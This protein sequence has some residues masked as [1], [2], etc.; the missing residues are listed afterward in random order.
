VRWLGWLL[1]VAFSAAGLAGADSAAALQAFQRGEY[2]KAFDIWLPLATQG[3]PDA[4]FGVAYL[5]TTGQ[6]PGVPVNYATAAKFYLGAAEQWHASAQYNLGLLYYDGRG[7][8]QDLVQAFVWFQL[9]AAGG[10]PQALAD[11]DRL[12]ARLTPSQID[13]AQQLA[14]EV[15]SR[16]NSRSARADAAEIGARAEEIIRMYT[17]APAQSKT[18]ATELPVASSE[19]VAGASAQPGLRSSTS[20]T[21]AVQPSS[22][23][24]QVRVPV[25][26]QSQAAEARGPLSG[27]DL[28]VSVS[29]LESR[30]TGLL[31]PG[32]D[33]VLLVVTDMTGDLAAAKLAKQAFTE[34][35]RRLPA[36]A[37]VGLLRAQDGLKVLLDPT[38]DRA[39]LASTVESVPVSGKAG[40]LETVESAARLGDAILSKAAVRLAVLFITDS[41]IKNYREDFINPVINTSDSRDISRRFR[42]ALVRERISKLEAS[43]TA[44][45]TPVFILHL[46]YRSDSLNEAYQ[47]GLLSLSG[48]TGA[49]AWFCR[50]QAEIAE[51]VRRAFEVIKSEYVMAVPVPAAAPSTV[52]IK[53]ESP[54]RVLDW[55]GRFVLG[56]D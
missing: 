28:T 4:Q 34:A 49:T 10:L 35:V 9:A 23:P 50:S 13:E 33:Q 29:G 18:G 43:L 46:S 27:N 30:P 36:N 41:D 31:G 56:G 44:S 55:R 12:A 53:L 7:V 5:Y 22:V 6:A 32:D 25:W 14:R 3:E 51:S 15:L 54:G 37:L 45:E 20:S 1:V 40:L 52:D 21:R 26:V 8:R 39:A 19:V 48:A 38:A 24:R 2:D 42:D 47:T 11:L 17:A 16:L